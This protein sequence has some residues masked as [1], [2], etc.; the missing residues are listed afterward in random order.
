[1]EGIIETRMRQYKEIKTKTM[2]VI[3]P[4]PNSLTQHIKQANIQ[5]YYCMHR[6]IHRSVTHVYLVGK[7]KWKPELSS[8]W[9]MT[10]INCLSH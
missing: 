8:L 3:L 9:N 1:M 6:M 4:D 2:Q 5:A 7:V 10:V